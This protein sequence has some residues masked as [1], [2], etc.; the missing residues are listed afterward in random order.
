MTL[1]DEIDRALAKQGSKA[2]AAGA[3]AYLKSDLAFYGVT[4]PVLR[5]T[6]LG[7]AKAARPDHDAVIAAALNAVPQVDL[8]VVEDGD[9]LKRRCE[10]VPSTPM[11]A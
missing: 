7:L 5:A 9:G 6:V 3:K 4:S 2:R 1:A 8:K 10:V 11:V